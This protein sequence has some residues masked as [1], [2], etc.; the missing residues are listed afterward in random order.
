LM[1]AS[2]GA[3]RTISSLV[4][5]GLGDFNGITRKEI[6]LGRDNQRA[7]VIAARLGRRDIVDQMIEAGVRNYEDIAT[8]A[9]LTNHW[10]LAEYMVDRWGVSPNLIAAYAAERG[11]LR[12]VDDM[13][14]RGATN[15]NDMI[16]LASRNGHHRIVD[17]VL[18]KRG[19]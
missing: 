1:A 15:F 4:D 13:I 9:A 11:N 6:E 2:N 5:R 7:A 17:Y 10:G 19:M 14:R 3:F 18:A 16:D 8:S 12:V